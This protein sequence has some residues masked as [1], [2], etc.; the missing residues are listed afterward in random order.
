MIYRLVVV[1]LIAGIVIILFALSARA[2]SPSDRSAI[3]PP[4]AALSP[5]AG[6]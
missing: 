2:T 4:A 1:T 6:R 5:D 3:A